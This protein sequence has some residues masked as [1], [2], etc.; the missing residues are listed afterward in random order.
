[1][2]HLGKIGSCQVRIVEGPGK[3]PMTS[4]RRA[5]GQQ[6]SVQHVRESAQGILLLQGCRLI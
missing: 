4:D 3:R 1:M 5:K 2:A 6:E